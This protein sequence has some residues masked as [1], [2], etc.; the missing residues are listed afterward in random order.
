MLQKML[1]VYVYA[2]YVRTVHVCLGSGPFM[3]P[4]H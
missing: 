4:K 3:W 2:V 1:D